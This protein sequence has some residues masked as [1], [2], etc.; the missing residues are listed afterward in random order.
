MQKYVF[1]FAKI[2]HVIFW[3]S[4]LSLFLP[5]FLFLSL[6]ATNYAPLLWGI[7]F[8]HDP[9]LVQSGQLLTSFDY[10][11]HHG[12]RC[13]RCHHDDP[14]SSSP[15]AASRALCLLDKFRLN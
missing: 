15:S 13:W 7:T 8:S 2:F 12:E 4:L 10:L 11:D 14:S 1:I 6:F 3:E 5:L 9:R